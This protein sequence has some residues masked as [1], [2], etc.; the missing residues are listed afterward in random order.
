MILILALELVLVC[1]CTASDLAD[2][3]PILG[4]DLV[5]FLLKTD[6]CNCRIRPVLGRM[7]F[8]ATLDHIWA[9]L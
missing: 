9:H 6:V 3:N 1:V 7:A 2:L 4:V 5:T 8:D